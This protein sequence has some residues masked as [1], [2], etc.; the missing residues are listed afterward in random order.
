MANKSPRCGGLLNVRMSLIFEIDF[1]CFCKPG[2][3][4]A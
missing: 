3:F 4:F 2:K 1:K